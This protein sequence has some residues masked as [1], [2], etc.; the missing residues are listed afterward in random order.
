MQKIED[1][2]LAQL[3]SKRSL[4]QTAVVADGKESVK[5]RDIAELFDIDIDAALAKADEDRARRIAAGIERPL[6]FD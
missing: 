1:K 5:I 3:E 2:I 4:G 6:N